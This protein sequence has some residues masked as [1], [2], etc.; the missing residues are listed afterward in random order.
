MKKAI[1]IW[2][3]AEPDLKKCINIAAKAGFAG[4]EP[5]IMGSGYITPASS[6]D[7]LISIK[8]YAEDKGVKIHSLANGLCWEFSLAADDP[9][10]RKKAYDIAVSQIKAA[11]IL[12]ASAVLIVPGGVS[13]TFRPGIEPIAYD[14]VY[15]RNLEVFSKLKSVAEEFEIRIGIENVW[16]GIFLSPLEMNDFIDKLGS[17]YVGV[18]FDVGNVLING[19]PEHWIKILG[20]RIVK[21]HFKDFRTNV[22]GLDGFVDLLSGDVNWCKVV[23]ALRE[24]NYDDWYTAEMTPPYKHFPEQIIFNTSSSMDKILS[25]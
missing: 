2:S 8:L 25:L 21:I 5:A 23:Q 16:N 9:D 3:F 14:I 7:E 10:E 15:E 22:A 13:S 11:K 24:I 12:G 17:Q 6:V 19:F 18:Y 20:S 4:I 1:N